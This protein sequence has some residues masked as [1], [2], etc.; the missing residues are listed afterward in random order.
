VTSLV[1]TLKKIAFVR[2]NEMSPCLS[3]AGIRDAST[4][5]PLSNGALCHAHLASNVSMLHALFSQRDDLLVPSQAL[6]LTSELRLLDGARLGWASFFTRLCL[7]LLEQ[8]CRLLC[9]AD[10]RETLGKQHRDT[11]RKVLGQM[12]TIADLSGLWS[13]FLDG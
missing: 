3:R 13:A 8:S 12:P 1:P 4:S 7:F 6:C 9:T 2:I 11:V 5:E 10:L